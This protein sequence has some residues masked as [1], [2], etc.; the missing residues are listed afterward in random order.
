MTKAKAKDFVAIAARYAGEVVSGKIPACQW[1]IK[2]CRRQLDDLERAKSNDFPY[3][4][5][6]RKASRIC[7]FIELLPHIKGEWAKAGAR[8]ELQ[9]WQVFI[10]TTVFGWIR[11][12]SGLRRFKTA[13]IEIPRKNGKSSLSS[14]VG[15][16]CTCADGEAGA[17]VYSAA[18][19]RDQAKI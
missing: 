19:T 15:I 6:K 14:G 13:Y 5:D 11:K 18:T 3:R 12:D 4:F 7:E 10:L 9:P 1:T 17:D 8:I 2:A 16:Y